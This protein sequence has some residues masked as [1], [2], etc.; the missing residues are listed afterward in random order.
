MCS[1]NKLKSTDNEFKMRVTLRGADCSEAEQ[2]IVKL[3]SHNAVRRRSVNSITRCQTKPQPTTTTSQVGRPVESTDPG[4][5]KL[6]LF[7]PRPTFLTHTW[8]TTPS[9][10]Q[11]GLAE[12]LPQSGSTC[13]DNI[14]LCIRVEMRLVYVV[15]RPELH[16]LLRRSWR[17]KQSPIL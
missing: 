8:C 15:S 17:G 6:T 14:A 11:T 9:H 1:S 4:F 12:T 2:T 7:Q 10:D 3:Y 5:P 13:D 16:S